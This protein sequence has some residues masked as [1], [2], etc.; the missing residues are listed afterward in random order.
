MADVQDGVTSELDGQG[1][2][3]LPDEEVVSLL[4]LNADLNLALDVTEGRRHGHNNRRGWCLRGSCGDTE[5]G[6]D[7]RGSLPAAPATPARATRPTCASSPSVTG[8]E[9]IPCSWRAT[10]A[11][12]ERRSGMSRSAEGRSRR[13]SRSSTRDNTAP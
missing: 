13:R 11:T 10:R 3:A 12:N 1:A 9:V 4:D 8:E 6:G 5:R 7:R 2:S